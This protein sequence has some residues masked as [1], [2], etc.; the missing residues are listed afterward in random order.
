MTPQDIP[1]AVALQRACFPAPFPE[2]LLWKAEHLEAHLEQFPQG[3]LVAEHNGQI[4][5]S[6]SS[7]IIAED[8]WQAHRDWDTTVGGPFLA[9]HDPH[10]TTLYGVDIS[11]HPEYRGQGVGRKLYEARFE[12]AK[13]LKRYGTAC[14]IP[15]YSKWGKGTVEQYVEAVARQEA[16]DRTLSPLLRYGLTLRGVIHGY[17]D[18][19]ESGNAAALIERLS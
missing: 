19:E 18:D 17:M 16:T 12:L 3:Q 5:A 2:N 6:A 10:G 1:A 8:N 7:L 4:V 13:T 15:D 11:V 9:N 14:R